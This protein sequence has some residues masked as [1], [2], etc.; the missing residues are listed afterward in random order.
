MASKVQFNLKNVYYA[1]LTETEVGG[2]WSE[3]YAT[4]VA[5]PGAV[6]INIDKTGERAVFYADGIEYFESYGATGFEGDLEMALIPDKM[7]K[8][9]WGDTEDANYV[10]ITEADTKAKPFA[11]LFQIDGDDESTLRVMYRCT[12]DRPAIASQTTTETTEP[13]TQTIAISATGRKSDN[14]V[15]AKT[16]ASTTT[17]TISSWFSAVYQ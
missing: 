11:L 14:K 2:V 10:L 3:S 16:T 15:L 13:Q 4:P 9:V 17:T 8:D 5:V 7:L 1:V 12:A 6:S